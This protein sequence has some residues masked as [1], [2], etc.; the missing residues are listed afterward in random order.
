MTDIAFETYHL[1]PLPPL[2]LP[3]KEMSCH[4]LTA[5][6]LKNINISGPSKHALCSGQKAA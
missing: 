4:L 6:I 1:S 5:A 3:P 2:P